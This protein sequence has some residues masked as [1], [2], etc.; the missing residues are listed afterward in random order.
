MKRTLLSI[1]VC[2]SCG[3]GLALRVLGE[4]GREITEGLLTCKGCG[5]SYP[6]IRG[7]ARMLPASMIN[8]HLLDSFMEKHGN[9][10]ASFGRAERSSTQ[11]VKE[12]TSKSF[13]FQWNVFSE[14]H[15]EY[16]KN[17]LNYVHPK[18]PSFF[19][20][21]KVLDAGCGFG[22]HTYYA[23][24]YGAD[25]VGFD[26][27]DAVDAAYR[28]CGKMPNVHI[29]Q[30]DIYNLPFRKAFDFVMS[31]GVLH[32]LPQPEKGY[33]SLVG[34]LR[35]GD[36]IF[37]WLYGSE[38][39]AF[40]TKFLEGTIRKAALRMPQRMLYYFCYLPASLYH[41]S[42][43][44]YRAL[45]RLGA[46]GTAE[47]IPFKNYA[48]FPFRVKLADSYDFLGTPINTYYTKEEATQ[49]AK[50]AGLRDISVTS[51]GGRSWRVFGRK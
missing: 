28:N 34:L 21:K 6:V 22:R 23:A 33:R 2:P 25:V 36:E 1:L 16:E 43:L 13:G 15:K 26:L 14:M 5:D 18:D 48:K 49:W 29:V 46:A 31:I 7:I 42:N 51:L 27:S 24:K 8:R 17:F 37:A 32:H 11:A 39:R 3:K 20:G 19:R 4:E 50:N 47:K 41:A 9:L 30:G 40:K 12:R 10:P 35:R 45:R 44:L 38:G